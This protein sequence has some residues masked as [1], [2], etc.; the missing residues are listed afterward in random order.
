MVIKNYVNFE[1]EIDTDWISI[2]HFELQPKSGEGCDVDFRG[3]MGILINIG[4]IL[5]VKS[6]KRKIIF[7]PKNGYLV[8]NENIKLVT[9]SGKYY[10]IT[11]ILIKNFF[12][13]EVRKKITDSVNP[14]YSHIFR[15]NR[16]VFDFPLNIDILTILEDLYKTD[17]RINTGMLRFELETKALYLIF[18]ILRKIINLDYKYI[19]PAA[20][21]YTKY[22]ST[23]KFV[24]ENMIPVEESLLLYNMTMRDFDAMF[25]KY[26]KNTILK[27][28]IDENIRYITKDTE[29]NE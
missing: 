7:P 21:K 12:M 1:K 15:S 5:V 6:G 2:Q 22:Y 13:K 25:K 23:L 28:F 9:T 14:C 18:L 8:S 27:E 17:T 19:E 16:Y 20:T 10:K 24:F 4:N 3:G 11:V 29:L 26:M